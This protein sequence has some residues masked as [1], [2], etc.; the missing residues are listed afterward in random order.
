MS[1]QDVHERRPRPQQVRMQAEQLLVAAV[2][3]DEAIF[4]VVERE[5]VGRSFEPS[6][7]C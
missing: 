5:P 7:S 3:H 6:I 2:A 1:A 4:G